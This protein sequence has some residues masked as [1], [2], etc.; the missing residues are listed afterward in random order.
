MCA[1]SSRIMRKY[2]RNQILPPL[3]DVHNRPEQGSTL[4]NHLCRL[5]TSPD[6][7]ARDLA[8]ELIFVLCK[9]N[10]NYKI[11]NTSII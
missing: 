5:L 8:A 2:L 9:E 1:S 3:T 7:R 4:R 6:R 10:G 11:S